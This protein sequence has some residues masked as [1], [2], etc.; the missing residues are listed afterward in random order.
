[1]I[2]LKKYCT[3]I[4]VIC[5]IVYFA[6]P[7]QVQDLSWKPGSRKITVNWMKPILN[8]YCVM[9]YVIYWV[10]AVSGSIDSRIVSSEKN[11]F[12]IENL[13]ACVEYEVSV[14]VVNEKNEGMDAVTGA[15]KTETAGNYH[16]QIILL[17]L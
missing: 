8:S 11:S 2:Y 10:H 9:Q 6:V 12:V 3:I 17:Y 13:D 14:R 4:P 5:N 1:M 15:T 7:G 16:A